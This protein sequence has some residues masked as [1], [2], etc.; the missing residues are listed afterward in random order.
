MANTWGMTPFLTCA[1]TECNTL[2]A[3]VLEI[4]LCGDEDFSDHVETYI[5]ALGAAQCLIYDATSEDCDGLI[6]KVTDNF[7]GYQ[8]HF[9]VDDTGSGSEMFAVQVHDEDAKWIGV[10]A[11][12]T[13]DSQIYKASAEV[14][15]TVGTAYT[16]TAQTGEYVQT[17]TTC[18]AGAAGQYCAW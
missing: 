8:I 10:T 4:C 3:S 5:T 2:I 14:T 9:N 1:A 7:D 18:G 15:A 13:A 12:S 16:L 17:D 6:D 11:F